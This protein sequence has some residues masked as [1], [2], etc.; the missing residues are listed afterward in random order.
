MAD[1]IVERVKNAVD[2]VEVI[3]DSVRL[4]KKG[5]SY[6]GLCPF[7]SEKTP[8]FSVSP[9]RQTWH[10]FGCGKGG[11]VFSFI[12]EKE[13]FSFPEALEYL[14]RRAGIDLPR[15]KAP[16]QTGD[17][18]SVMEAAVS[19]YQRELNGN[20]GAVGRGYLKRRNISPADAE[21]FELGWSPSSWRVLGDELKKE[22]ISQDQLLKCGLVIEGEK[23]CYDRFR[24]RVI[25]P[26]RNVSGRAIALGGRMVDGEGAKYLNSPE[27]PLY[28]KKQNLYL[29]NKAKSFIREKKRSILVEGYMDA[30]RLHMHGYSETVAS[31]GTALTEEQSALLKRF[32]DRCYICYDS[33]T[34]GQDA[35]LRGMYVL[36]RAGLSVFVVQLPAGKDPDELLQ[37]PD[38]G[39]LFE[40]ALADAQ[41]LVM[42]HIS[43]F[44][45]AAR[46]GGEAKAAIEMLTGM[47]RLSAVELSPYMQEIAKAVGLPD[48]QLVS[49]LERLRRGRPAAL[50]SD[51][52]DER[53]ALPDE[54]EER[55]A[56]CDP[57]EMSLLYLL[58]NSKQLRLSA[59]IP[60]VLGLISDP[61]LKDAAAAILS[62]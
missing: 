45:A 40:N 37:L 16:G 49:E 32:S 21:L 12:M 34:A 36:Q 35:T 9:E 39:E 44:K 28:N 61:R 25:F 62:G 58:W 59:S 17:L 33:D 13:G 15:R 51:R 42:H 55:S 7:H 8:S 50:A 30:I 43:L 23:G 31:L 6:G 54:P 46:Q 1:E 10:C 38:G 41:P 20:A 24:G 57:G 4:V 56:P 5:R 19:F 11:D 60:E 26:I 2:I 29:L 48:Y 14:A 18:Y 52:D 3:G 47:S 22:G 27:G 53:I